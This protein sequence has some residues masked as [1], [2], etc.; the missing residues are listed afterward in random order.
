[1]SLWFCLARGHCLPNYGTVIISGTKGWQMACGDPTC[2]MD[3]HTR[4]RENGAHS[5]NKHWETGFGE[6]TVQMARGVR[7]GLKSAEKR[8]CAV[9][10][11]AAPLF[12]SFSLWS[13]SPWLSILWPVPEAVIRPRPFQGVWKYFSPSPS[14]E[15]R[16]P[17]MGQIWLSLNASIKFLK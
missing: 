1:M 17:S 11:N 15:N 5:R 7:R 12:F 4:G 9:L 6:G 3:I 16:E 10:W 14:R 2:R 8:E 13:H